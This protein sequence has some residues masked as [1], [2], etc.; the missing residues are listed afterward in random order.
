MY[1]NS[2]QNGCTP[3]GGVIKD[4]DKIDENIT[5]GI[6][7]FKYLHLLMDSIWESGDIYM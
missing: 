1:E 2:Q 7:F 6:P 4:L 3:R 5:N